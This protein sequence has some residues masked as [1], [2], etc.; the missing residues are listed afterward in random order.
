MGEHTNIKHEQYYLKIVQEAKQAIEGVAENIQMA[1]L[2]QYTKV[3]K[4]LVLAKQIPIQGAKSKGSYYAIS[5]R[6]DR[7]SCE[8]YQRNAF[9]FRRHKV[10]QLC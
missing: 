9:Y 3:V 5:C 1:T 4:R 7:L 6:M 2:D 10:L 8:L